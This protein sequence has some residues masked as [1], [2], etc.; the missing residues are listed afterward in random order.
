MIN[1]NKHI[2]SVI[3]ILTF[4]CK[5]IK[6]LRKRYPPVQFILIKSSYHCLHLYAVFYSQYDLVVH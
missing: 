5:F 4:G 3:L 6:E 1:A 2:E